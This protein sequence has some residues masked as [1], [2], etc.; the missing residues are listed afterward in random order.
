M[1]P[2]IFVAWVPSCPTW[3]GF[4]YCTCHF[5]FVWLTP[6]YY[7]RFQQA[8]SVQY[9][10]GSYNPPFKVTLFPTHTIHFTNNLLYFYFLQYFLRKENLITDFLVNIWY[11]VISEAVAEFEYLFLGDRIYFEKLES[12]IYLYYQLNY[13]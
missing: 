1:G 11:T 9:S 10:F 12:E 13:P 7:Q 3:S 2:T 4:Y 6:Q 8:N 5:K